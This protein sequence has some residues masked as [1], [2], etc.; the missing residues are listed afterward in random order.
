MASTQN[1]LNDFILTPQQQNLLFAALNS[2]RQPNASPIN[3]AMKI[4][5]SSY[6]SSP[7][8]NGYLESPFLDYDNYELAGDNSFDFSFADDSQPKMIG[9]LPGSNGSASEG[10]A[11]ASSDNNDNE[12]RNHPD[13]EDDEEEGAAKRQETG[14]KAPKKPGRKPLT[15][16]PTSVSSILC[17]IDLPSIDTNASVLQKRKAQNRAAQRAFRER[18]EKHLKDLE[19]KVA[20]L[21][22]ASASTNQQNSQ[23]RAQVEKMT[24]E[25]TEYKKKVSLMVNNRAPD[26]STKRPTFGHAVIG[27]LNDVNFQFEFPKF[28]Q[29]PGPT[30]SPSTHAVS[31]GRPSASP[32]SQR[33]PSSHTSPLDKAARQGSDH[34]S[35]S[36]GLD[37]QTKKDLAKF[38][39]IFS[40]PLTNNNIASAARART[41]SQNSGVATTESSPSCSSNSNG[42]PSSSCGTSPE[43]TNNQSPMGFKL[44]ALTTI[45]EENQPSL[46]NTNQGKNEPSC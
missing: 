28:G 22:K 25:L 15:T 31:D 40:P 24:V 39:G 11:K 38:S 37:A 16:E 18:K 42:G 41:D 8:Q 7:Q 32:R 4:S 20:E 12:K 6:N 1:P 43:P 30:P 2:N 35:P 3:T 10:S 13:D 46:S 45:G 27:N 5:P 26:M 36:N 9:D 34:S 44:E 21:E 14:E 19:T 29:L 23:L 33:S 17:K